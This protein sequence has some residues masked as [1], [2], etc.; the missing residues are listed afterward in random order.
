MTMIQKEQELRNFA[1]DMSIISRELEIVEKELENIAE[2]SDKFIQGKLKNLF[3]SG[4]RLRPKLVL[5]SGLCFSSINDAMI[6]T[7]IAA[8]LIHTASLVHDDIIDKSDYRRNMPTINSVCGNHIAVLAGDFLFAKA[9]EILSENH[10]IEGMRYLVIAIQQMCN[11]EVLQ[12]ENLFNIHINEATYFEKTRYKTASLL[13]ACCMAGAQ[14]GGASAKIIK[15][16]GIYGHNLG[17]AFQIIDDILDF[18]GDKKI[19]GKPI[20]HDLEEGNITLP[21][22]YLLEDYNYVLKYEKFL[23]DSLKIKHI[24]TDII[25]D[26]K[27]SNALEKAYE[28]A[29]L[30]TFK[31]AEA[32]DSLPD[33]P[34]KNLL[35]EIT[36]RIGC[37]QNLANKM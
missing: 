10:L 3:C 11:G 19:I 14:S 35:I 29:L 7:A 21:I 15:K 9:F 34:Y 17:I 4:K 31:A 36:K 20:A 8:E 13:S 28:K 18:V 22:I 2:G 6:N 5:L 23:K 25:Q 1:E 32:L 12:A 33:L 24:K 26:L 27:K 30:F 37:P 16:F